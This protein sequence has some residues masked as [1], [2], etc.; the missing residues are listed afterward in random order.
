MLIEST[1]SN[2]PYPRAYV[3]KYETPSR[4]NAADAKAAITATILGFILPTIIFFIYPDSIWLNT[5]WQIFPLSTFIYNKL[6]YLIFAEEPNKPQRISGAGVGDSLIGQFYLAVFVLGTA[7][8]LQ[9]WGLNLPGTTND[10]IPHFITFLDPKKGHNFQHVSALFL[11][12]DVVFIY[13]GALV[14]ACWCGQ[15]LVEGIQILGWFVLATPFIG[16]TAAF[17]G[18]YYWREQ[19]IS[20]NRSLKAQ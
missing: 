9:T 1:R 16:P 17:A 2:R 10:F 15:T 19:K 8:H 20:Q 18:F 13:A 12:W 4:I 11:H 7:L 14:A 5:L 3:H 6:S